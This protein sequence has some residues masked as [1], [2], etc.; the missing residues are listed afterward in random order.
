MTDY[1]FEYRQKLKTPEEAARLVKNG[2]WVEYGTALEMPDLLDKA[3][4]ARKDELFDIRVRG[5]L[6]LRP[7]AVV[8]AD[9]ERKTF[10]YE[11]YYFG[12]YERKLHEKG[13]CDFVPM[14]Y[15]WLPLIYRNHLSVDVSFLSVP[16]MDKTGY[17]NFSLT[18]GA[19]K[20]MLE[21]SRTIVLEINENLPRVP[22]GY[23]EQ[24][25]I[26]EVDCVV[27]GEHAPLTEF[28]T[29]EPSDIDKQIAQKIVEEIE[30]GS[31]IELGIGGLPAAVGMYI[32]QSDLKD[33]GVHT[34]LF[35]DSFYELIKSGKITNQNKKI[36]RGKSVW[37]FALGTREFYEWAADNTTLLSYPV[38][39]VN[40]PHIMAQNEKLITINNCVEV[41][42]FGQICA[43]SAGYRQIS[44]TG[45]QLDF[46]TG[47]F[48]S[49]GGKS[50]ICMT[51]TYFDK[52]ENRTKSR[53]VPALKEG[54]IITDPRGCNFC[55]ITEWGI[56][57]LVG[58][59]VWERAEALISIAHPDFRDELIRDAEKKKIWRR[60]NK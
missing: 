59:C 26:S 27:E 42:L 31:T 47:G 36:N 45:G 32:A 10:R 14:D 55:V 37:T 52:K 57:N 28:K 24:I 54:G 22:G 35:S 12:G 49:K 43:E 13:L 53:V 18:N 5:L 7:I 21:K 1:S 3:L 48:F 38:D 46:L 11:S 56:I 60:S 30:D 8:E 29:P 19:T 6:A 16:P 25:H 51:S 33:L 4:A 20:A 58:K 44:G 9:P 39:Y 15:G 23:D 2:D 17:F 50:F 40:A 41:D 34:E